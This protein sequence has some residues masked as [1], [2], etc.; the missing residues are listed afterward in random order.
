[1]NNDDHIRDLQMRRKRIRPCRSLCTSIFLS[2]FFAIDK[3]RR[4][5][6]CL[7]GRDVM[8]CVYVLN[9]ARS[10]NRATGSGTRRCDEEVGSSL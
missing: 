10:T 2:R 4:I 5:C 9:L 3:A 7:P 1:M 6:A 8:V